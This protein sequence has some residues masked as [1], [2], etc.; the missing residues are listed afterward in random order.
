MFMY[1]YLYAYACVYRKAMFLEQYFVVANAREKPV[2][3]PAH[4]FSEAAILQIKSNLD[5]YLSY[6]I[7]FIHNR[8]VHAF[9][10]SGILPQQY[11]NFCDFAGIGSIGKRYILGGMQNNI[12]HISNKISCS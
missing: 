6:K 9:T 10:C 11:I 4:S 12:A 8:L 5:S 2:L 3:G 7:N 1:T